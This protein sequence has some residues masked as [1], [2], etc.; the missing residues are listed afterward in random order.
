M[1]N[2]HSRASCLTY[3]SG[4]HE[5]GALI[6]VAR[7]HVRYKLLRRLQKQNQSAHQ[8]DKFVAKQKFQ[9]DSPIRKQLWQFQ[10]HSLLTGS[11][12]AIARNEAHKTTESV[13]AKQQRR[14]SDGTAHAQAE[15]A[16]AARKTVKRIATVA[17]DQG[18]HTKKNRREQTAAVNQYSRKTSEAQWNRLLGQV[19]AKM[20]ISCQNDISS[21]RFTCTMSKLP[22]AAHLI[23]AVSPDCAI[24]QATNQTN[25]KL[26]KWR[27]M[28]AR[29]QARSSAEE[30]LR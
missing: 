30:A 11:Q 17:S 15:A 27:N 12:P 5:G 13:G 22:A 16:P 14:P 28:R 6:V 18:E 24:K 20:L 1:R 2:F 29:G 21:R 23:S 19:L 10:S 9:R 26:G 4:S 3:S 25:G 8:A 7:V